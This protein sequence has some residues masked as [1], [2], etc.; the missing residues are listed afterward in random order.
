MALL[1]LTAPP[2]H[3]HPDAEIRACK[4]MQQ[5]VRRALM[6]A[7]MTQEAAALRIPI[8]DG[9]MSMLM[10]GKRDWSVSKLLKLMR[11]TGSAAPLQWMAQNIGATV[12]LDELAAKEAYANAILAEVRAQRAA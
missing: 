12:H 1:G 10:T 2:M 4:T 8:T 11:V 5:A 3:A 7:G 9:G 6:H